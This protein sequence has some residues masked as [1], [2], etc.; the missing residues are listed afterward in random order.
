MVA[1]SVAGLGP[2]GLAV[3]SAGLRLYAL[4]AA[5]LVAGLVAPI[6]GRARRPVALGDARQLAVLAP[7]AR[8]PAGFTHRASQAREAGH[9]RVF[10]RGE[11][12]PPGHDERTLQHLNGVADV[13]AH[14]LAPAERPAPLA[15]GPAFARHVDE[16]EAALADATVGGTGAH[17]ALQ[18]AACGLRRGAHEGP[19]ETIG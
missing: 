5:L 6:T 12:V 17:G 14:R 15:A 8:Q 13:A 3:V 2:A 7:V 4:L 10:L 16:L 9:Q 1:A 19:W 18:R 11:T